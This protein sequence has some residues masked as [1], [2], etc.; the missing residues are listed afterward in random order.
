MLKVIYSIFIFFLLN[1]PGFSQ[2]R[3]EP[4]SAIMKLAAVESPLSLNALLNASLLLSGVQDGELEKYREALQKIVRQIPRNIQEEEDDYRKGELLLNHIHHEYLTHYQEW[5]TRIDLLID[6]GSFNCV[7][8]AIFYLI[9][10]R[11]LGLSIKGIITSDHAFCIISTDTGPID[12]ETTNPYG[13]EPGKQ[14]EF[15]NVFGQTGFSY[16]PPGN[17]KDR[18]EIDDK[19]LLGLIIQNRIS[20]LEERGQFEPALELA[21]DRYWF[22]QNLT[23]KTELIRELNNYLALLNQQGRY[24]EALD[25]LE[26]FDKRYQWN[27]EYRDITYTLV[28]NGIISNL[29]KQN[30]EGAKSLL[31]LWNSSLESEKARELH[32]MISK[33][34]VLFKIQTCSFEEGVALLEDSL[35][36]EAITFEVYREGIAFIFGKKAASLGKEGQFLQALA[37]IED[38]ISRVGQYPGLIQARDVFRHNYTATIHNRFADLYNA[39]KYEEAINVLREG[40]TMVPGNQIL[41][42]DLK[43]ALQDRE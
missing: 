21:V 6:N 4:R 24:R 27:E 25:Y 2:P 10:G 38:A 26:Q 33:A 16:V 40:L 18:I 8:S 42:R 13:F 1:P 20:T 9:L 17:Y 35:E 28:Y 7:S 19:E 14:R 11:S 29:E 36:E 22:D 12:V 41:D 30:H 37:C 23:N 31:T 43:Q 34:E 3:I 5:Q 32:S 39:G 15:E